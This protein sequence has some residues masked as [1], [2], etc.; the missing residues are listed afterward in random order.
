MATCKGPLFS[1]SAS[2]V[3][4]GS[5]VYTSWKGRAVVRAHAVPANPKSG[6]QL[7]MRAMLKFLSQY[8]TNLSTSEKADWD[9]RAAVTNISP[10]NAYVAYNMDRWGV[11]NR[12]SQQDPAAG[13]DAAGV[14]SAFTAVAQS[15][16][17]LVTY[18]IA[19]L[20]QNWGIAIY[21]GLT[22]A[23]GVTRSEMVQVIV[24]ESAA[25]FTW[26]DFPLTAGVAQYYRAIPFSVEGVIGAAED[27]ITATPT[28]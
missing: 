22:A 17:V 11:N 24:G 4:G 23:M 14:S 15:R 6:G 20:N 21:R 27:D 28:T 9:T 5:I 1:I 26:L 19:T 18:T 25:A 7:S 3:L 8:W 13:T 16:A 2:G 12:P 10:F